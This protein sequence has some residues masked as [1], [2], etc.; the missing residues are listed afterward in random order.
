MAIN[1]QHSNE[2]VLLSR[3]QPLSSVIPLRISAVRRI[4]AKMRPASKIKHK[5]TARPAAEEAVDND[6][7]ASENEK[8]EESDDHDE[9][10]TSG[11]SNVRHGHD[12]DEE[13]ES[14]GESDGAND[15][16]RSVDDDEAD[17]SGAEKE[18]ENDDAE[19]GGNRELILSEPSSES[20]DAEESDGDGGSAADDDESDS[21]AAA[22]SAKQK[23]GKMPAK[24]TA[25]TATQTAGKFVTAKETMQ[26]KQE[27]AK[28]AKKAEKPSIAMKKVDKTELAKSQ[29][30]RGAAEDAGVAGRST[31]GAK[32]APKAPAKAADVRE[33]RQTAKPPVA[34]PK[35][36]VK[37]K[38][39]QMDDI[40][41]DEANNNAGT[42]SN[43]YEV[44][45]IVDHK[46]KN[47]RT[48][49]KIRWKGYGKED[50]TWQPYETLDW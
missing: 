15:S 26:L 3:T 48:Y 5:N 29:T 21:G 46:R 17:E 20:E 37:K 24:I 23:T 39:Q 44:E 14:E 32:K 43:V 49:Y 7:F 4:V 40:R 19:N 9:A 13:F 42:S 38:P 22:E 30:R 8:A 11:R 36:A 12:E 50:D 34:E 10:E 25:A 47:G 27:A 2:Q 16:R 1:T 31:A 18:A 28:K 6:P 33:T 41:D 35:Q 45:A